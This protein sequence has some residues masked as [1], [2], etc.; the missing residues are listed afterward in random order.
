MFA[1]IIS[2]YLTI[3]FIVTVDILVN[4][5][6]S[7]GGSFSSSKVKSGNIPV[8]GPDGIAVDSGKSFND[9][10][11]DDKSLWS[12][13]RI[14]DYVKENT[15]DISKIINDTDISKDK[16]W[17]SEQITDFATELTD[18]YIP[19]VPGV[20]VNHIPVF[21]ENGRI[22][23]SGRMFDDTVKSD[24]S[25]W[26]S[27]KIQTSLDG[28]LRKF[29]KADSTTPKSIPLINPDGELEDSKLTIDDKSGPADNILWTS[30]RLT[31]STVLL[32]IQT[33]KVTT[34]PV[35][36]PVKVALDSISQWNGKGFF[37]P[38]KNGRYLF[39]FRF[40][41]S[42]TTV[43]TNGFLTLVLQK[44]NL[45]NSSVRIYQFSF[46]IVSLFM[47]EGTEI[48]EMTRDKLEDELNPTIVATHECQIDSDGT[49][50]FQE[51]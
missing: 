34:S 40:F 39:N 25:I 26:S 32:D 51:L 13:K 33:L 6:S 36:V 17:S 16:T 41:A 11:I 24:T 42:A 15:T 20:K 4:R 22:A 31:K 7:G 38:R 50:S 18:G 35:Q 8:G 37:R 19:L 21:L 12:S 29:A 47:C 5:R 45:E 1:T 48:I 46:P 28:K 49:M 3:L 44:R 9:T 14:T 10:K 27:N 23:D 43:P 30:S 2:L